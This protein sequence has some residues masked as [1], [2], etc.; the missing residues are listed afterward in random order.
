MLVR[1]NQPSAV[2]TAAVVDQA[3]VHGGE[4]VYIEPGEVELEQLHAALI[5]FIKVDIFSDRNGVSSGTLI[6]LTLFIA[7]MVAG[8]ISAMSS[9]RLVRSCT[10]M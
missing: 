10:S 4:H 8:P 6:F 5:G 1:Q 3:V 9:M 7:K 2:E